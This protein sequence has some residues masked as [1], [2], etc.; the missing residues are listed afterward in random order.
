VIDEKKL[1]ERLISLEAAKSWSRRVVSRLKMLLRSGTDEDL[2]PSSEN[3]ISCAGASQSDACRS[4]NTY[5]LESAGLDPATLRPQAQQH[6]KRLALGGW[7]MFAGWLEKP[8]LQTRW[9]NLV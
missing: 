6:G 4:A 8:S 5:A 2:S 7:A 1:Q 9:R 3:C